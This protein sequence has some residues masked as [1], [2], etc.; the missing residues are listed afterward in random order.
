MSVNVNKVFMAGR[1]ASD[2]EVRETNG[3]KV[4]KFRFVTNRSFKQNDEWKTVPTFIACDAWKELAE[5]ASK[6]TKGTEVFLQARLDQDEWTDGDGNKR[7]AHKLTVDN[8]QVLSGG[9]SSDGD[10]QQN[11]Q[12][13]ARQRQPRQKKGASQSNDDLP[14]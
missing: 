4:A 10:E 6:L 13:P 5:R 2:V 9:T 1:I 14:F 8:L 11:E 3:G 7:S 12:Q